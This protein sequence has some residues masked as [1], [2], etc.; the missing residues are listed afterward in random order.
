MNMETNVAGAEFENRQR[1]FYP[2]STEVMALGG[3]A[4][5]SS[6]AD[7]GPPQEAFVSG[8]IDPLLRPVD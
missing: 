7:W 8:A 5:D 6:R 3:V 4:V 1:K 2:P